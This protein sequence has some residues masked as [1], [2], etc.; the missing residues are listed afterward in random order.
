[1]PSRKASER[2]G[3]RG[4]PR[5]VRVAKE[6][7]KARLSPFMCKNAHAFRHILQK[8]YRIYFSFVLALARAAVEAIS[9]IE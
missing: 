7:L 6:L 9:P 3:V 1:M 2:T 4:Y 5:L 8:A